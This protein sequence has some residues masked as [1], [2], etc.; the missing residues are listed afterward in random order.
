MRFDEP[1]ATHIRGE[2]VDLERPL[3]RLAAGGQIVEVELE[4]FNVVEH[5]IPLV[6]GLDVNGPD[7]KALF[8]E[9]AHQPAADESASAGDDDEIV[10][11]ERVSRVERA[12]GARESIGG[13]VRKP[14][15]GAGYTLPTS[16]RFRRGQSPPLLLSANL[17]AGFMRATRHQ[18][19]LSA[20]S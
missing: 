9:M 20:R 10:G 2:I 1:H 18:P 3:A 16:G 13:G 4:V 11:H 12:P 6:E 15:H 19:R 7:G 5:L 14:A 17:R 8:A